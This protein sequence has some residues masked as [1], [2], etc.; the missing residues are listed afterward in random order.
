M[1]WIVTFV[2]FLL[3]FLLMALGVLAGR[4]RIQGSCG[5]I[6]SIGLEKSCDC[7]S[8]CTD[9]NTLYQIQEPNNY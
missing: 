6:A 1:E 8:V 7:E 2:V 4:K 3:V 5:G 9:H